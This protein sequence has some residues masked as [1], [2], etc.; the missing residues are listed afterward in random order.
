MMSSFKRVIGYNASNKK[1]GLTVNELLAFCQALSESDIDGETPVTVMTKWNSR[2]VS[3]AADENE[4]YKGK[5]AR[6]EPED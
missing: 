6:P 4:L 2:L 1:H 3:I 5:T